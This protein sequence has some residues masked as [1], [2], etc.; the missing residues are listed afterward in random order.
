MLQIMK[1]CFF[2][3]WWCDCWKWLITFTNRYLQVDAVLFVAAHCC[4][5]CKSIP[6][7][8]KV[9]IFPMKVVANNP[10][11]ASKRMH[12]II[13]VFSATGIRGFTY[14]IC[15]LDMNICISTTLALKKVSSC[16]IL[17][18]NKATVH[19][20]TGY[21][22]KKYKNALLFLMG[23]PELQPRIW[24]IGNEQKGKGDQLCL[25]S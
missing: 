6:K 25:S 9:V 17:P 1:N 24:H 19:Q 21:V 22:K 18:S 3:K 2:S 8:I 16:P 23:T 20:Y 4:S 11:K 15:N 13:G 10:K 7:I 14:S 12:Y 5:I